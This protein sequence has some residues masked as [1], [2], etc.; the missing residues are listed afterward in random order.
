MMVLLDRGRTPLVCKS[1]KALYGLSKHPDNGLQIFL[2]LYFPLVSC[3]LMHHA[4]HSL[5]TQETYT[6]FTTI[7]IYVDDLIITSNYKQ[8]DKV[9]RLLYSKFH[10]KGL[11]DLG[12]K[13]LSWHGVL[14]IIS[15]DI[16]ISKNVFS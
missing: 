9:T 15:R 11:G 6:T 2:V 1:K 3:Y 14:Q 10:M 7:L 12:L 5:F 13:L 4:N 8:V 16:Y